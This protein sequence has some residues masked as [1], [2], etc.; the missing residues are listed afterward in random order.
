MQDSLPD[1][2][3]TNGWPALP[4]PASAVPSPLAFLAGRVSHFTCTGPAACRIYG[5]TLESRRDNGTWLTPDLHDDSF[6]ICGSRKWFHSR[7]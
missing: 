6:I 1:R 3:V 4:V 7:A 2:P 5:I